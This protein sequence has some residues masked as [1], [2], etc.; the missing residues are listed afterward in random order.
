MFECKKC[1]SDDFELMEKG[2]QKGLYCAKCGTWIKWLGKEE[3]NLY[4]ILKQR[5][6]AK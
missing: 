1:K 6:Q 5:S 4:K 3:H 2:T